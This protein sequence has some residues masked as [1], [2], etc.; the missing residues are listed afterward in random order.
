MKRVLIVEDHPLVAE[1]TS[2][3][4][5]A[6]CSELSVTLAHNAGQA[7]GALDYCDDWYRILLDLD[8]PGASGLSVA[9]T[10]ASR[11]LAPRCCVISA[12]GR[13][14]TVDE[15][16]SMGFLGYV[17]KSVT[18]AELTHSLDLIL[19][20]ERTYSSLEVGRISPA[21][22]LTR[23][24]VQLLSLASDGLSSKQIARVAGITEG[25]INNHFNAILRA[26]AVT[27]RTH[28]VARGIELGLIEF[29]GSAVERPSEFVHGAFPL[30]AGS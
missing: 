18:V 26:L 21:S 11:G 10:V 1:A 14:E 27:N 12:L 8:I 16:R 24:Q 3:L 5:K 20:G 4:L 15:I 29:E 28:A 7:V 6:R 2:E 23:R 25:T 13:P 19:A 30:R 22:V 17:S 9:R